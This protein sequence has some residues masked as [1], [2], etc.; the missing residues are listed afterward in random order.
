MTLLLCGTF[1]LAG[2]AWEHTASAIYGDVALMDVKPV[3]SDTPQ[4]SLQLIDKVITADL[5]EWNT[6]AK[7]LQECYPAIPYP[8]RMIAALFSGI[9]RTANELGNY[10]I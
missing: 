3:T 8:I 4:I 5:S 7:Y 1:T 9:Q 10:L 2:I 6:A